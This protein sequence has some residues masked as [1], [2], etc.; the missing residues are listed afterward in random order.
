MDKSG[1]LSHTAWDCKHHVKFIPKRRRRTL[2]GESRKHLGDVFRKLAAQKGSE[3][4]EGHLMPGHVPMIL[5][6]PRFRQTLL[7]R[8]PSRTC[9]FPFALSSPTTLTLVVC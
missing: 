6:I 7:P 1:S 8:C 3:T 4:A 2:N 9:A 5:A